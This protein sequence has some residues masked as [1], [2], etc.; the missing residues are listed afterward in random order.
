MKLVWLPTALQTLGAQIDYIARDNPLAAAGQHDKI[1]QQVRK[2]SD[3]PYLGRSGRLPNTRELVVPGTPL[4]VI[5][6]V[7]NQ[8]IEILRLLHGAR[9]WPP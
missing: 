3:H 9:R 4:V 7:K 5:Y 6:R 1:E 2:L 8:R